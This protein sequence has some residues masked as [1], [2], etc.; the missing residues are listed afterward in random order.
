[1]AYRY[2][3]I[4][5]SPFGMALAGESQR[6]GEDLSQYPFVYHKSHTHSYGIQMETLETEDGK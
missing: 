2:K 5:S 6:F 3:K 4:K 1:M